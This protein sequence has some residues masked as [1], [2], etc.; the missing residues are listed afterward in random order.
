[1]GIRREIIN[2]LNSSF[3]LKLEPDQVHDIIEALEERETDAIERYV[4]M[5]DVTKP[6][7][8]YINSY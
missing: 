3:G 2:N 4:K 7:I 8:L 5:M 6:D 1:M